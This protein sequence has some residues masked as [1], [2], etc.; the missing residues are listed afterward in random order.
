MHVHLSSAG[1]PDVRARPFSALVAIAL[2]VELPVPGALGALASHHCHATVLLL[3]R[4]LMR[5]V[6]GARALAERPAAA[7]KYH[8][9]SQ[10]VHA[11]A[12]G[13]EHCVL[14]HGHGLR[15][16]GEVTETCT[17]HAGNV[18]N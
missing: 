18:G 14:S 16:G 9:S 3:E 15:L 10:A 11:A 13:E 7:C 6:G 4:I 5:V 12:E 1:D 2:V 8:D 17:C